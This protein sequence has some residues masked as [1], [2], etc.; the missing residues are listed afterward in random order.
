MKVNKFVYVKIITYIFLIQQILCTH[1]MYVGA[2]TLVHS[3]SI[4]PFQLI[5]L[6]SPLLKAHGAC[7]PT[8]V[9]LVDVHKDSPP[10]S[11]RVLSI[12]FQGVLSEAYILTIF[13]VNNCSIKYVRRTIIPIMFIPIMRYQVLSYFQRY[14]SLNREKQETT[15]LTD[16]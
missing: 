14:V 2:H 13:S 6:S 16:C 10:V 1:Y 7:I 12:D 4:H 15:F 3:T 9:T 11:F 5:N 8:E